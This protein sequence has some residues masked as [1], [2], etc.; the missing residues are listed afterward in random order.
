[1]SRQQPGS[2]EFE[3]IQ[4]CFTQGYPT[5]AATLLGIGDD[6]SVIA[7]PADQHLAQSLDTQVA[8]VHFPANAP[9]HLIAQRALRC[10]VSDLAAM[11]ASPQGFLL[12]LT[13]P[14]NQPDWLDDFA[15][16]LRDAATACGITLLGG[17]TTR[18]PALVISLLVQ[19]W[20]PALSHPRGLTR[21]GAQAGDD[22]WVSGCL[23]QAALALPMVLANPAIHTGLAA[24]YYYPAPRLTLG[25]SLLGI[26]TA[27]LDISDGL[28][29]DAHHI[30]TASAVN[31]ALTGEHIPTAVALGHPG[32]PDCLS[33][34]DD[35]ELL[36]TAPADQQTRI[37]TLAQQL[38]VPL[39]R[40]GQCQSKI[41]DQQPT[42][43]VLLQDQP[44]QLTTSG[45]QHF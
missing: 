16:G 10:A 14:D 5:D 30:A 26:A 4:R 41:N 23:G 31:L 1:M 32:W 29:Q 25:Q 12:G 21:G 35:Y 8:D 34:G 20:V 36:F 13:L 40:I 9:A 19:G 3:L 43:T 2:S 6:A 7:P 44:V 28:L 27:A 11:G 17:D 42:V 38:D 15:R 33:G 24:A 45:Y 22:V 39:T 37:A 18:G